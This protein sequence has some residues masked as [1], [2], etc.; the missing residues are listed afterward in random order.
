MPDLP[1]R[2]PRRTEETAPFWDACAQHRLALPRCE[3]CAQ[4]IWY[5]RRFCPACGGTAI[6]WEEM[7][8]NG[9]IYTFT[10]VRRGQGPYKEV[11]PYVLAYV[12]L[13]EGP[14]ILTNV[15]TDDVE[16]VRCG[17]R[18]RVRFDPAG[19]SDA[20]FRFEPVT[21]TGATAAV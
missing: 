15:V 17:Q 20:I 9:S 3:S 16:A 2:P 4:L 21:G 19:D 5:P 11:A 10:I 1:T 12:E 7:S 13:D 14:R 6:S 8:G 18:V